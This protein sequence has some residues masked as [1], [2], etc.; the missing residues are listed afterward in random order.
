[1]HDVKVTVYIDLSKQT[2]SLYNRD[3]TEDIAHSL[4][5]DIT[6]YLTENW[7]LSV[8]DFFVM[9]EYKAEQTA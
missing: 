4:T 5:D 7:G 8:E 2:K 1:M 6:L 3:I 9:L